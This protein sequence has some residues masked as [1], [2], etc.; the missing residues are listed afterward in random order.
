MSAPGQDADA[1]AR[2]APGLQGIEGTTLS[3]ELAG[4]I[5][6]ASLDAILTLTPEGQIVDLNRAAERLY[7]VGRSAI[8]EPLTAF[9]PPR[10]RQVW[11]ELLARLRD[12]PSHLRDRRIEGTGRRADESEFPLEASINSLKA[13]EHQ[14]FVA[15]NSDLTTE[16]R[17]AASRAS[18]SRR[19]ATLRSVMSRTKATK[20]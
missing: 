6:A 5:M 20:N 8:G 2:A 16:A 13:G 7:K 19:S 18:A 11:E 17:R 4:A 12:D 15:R 1:A 3:A 14:F 10:D 9:I